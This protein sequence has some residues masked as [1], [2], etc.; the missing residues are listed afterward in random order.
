MYPQKSPNISGEMVNRLYHLFYF[1][2]YRLLLVYWFIF[3]PKVRG[4]NVAIWVKG[5]I[6]LVRPCYKNLFSMPGGYIK[7]REDAK[8]AAIREL[9]EELNL[10]VYRNDLCFVESILTT[11]EY[12][13]DFTS[14]FETR[15]VLEPKVNIDNREVIGYG[16]FSL[17]DA[18]SLRLQETVRIYLQKV[19]ESRAYCDEIETFSYYTGRKNLQIFTN[20]RK[21]SGIDRRSGVDRRKSG[22][23]RNLIYIGRERRVIRER[24]STQERR[25]DWVRC[26]R[27]SSVPIEEGNSRKVQIS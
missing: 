5:K 19:A 25:K 1:F 27:W 12:K 18:L 14:V 26:S 4:V 22:R 21:R 16:F 7:S 11:N 17:E 9:E 10:I 2:A 8:T 20:R 3:R 23:V 13:Y 6:L 15:R 24:R